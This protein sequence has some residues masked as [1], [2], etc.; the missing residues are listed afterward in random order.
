M[1][2]DRIS[3]RDAARK[4]AEARRMLET[5]RGLLAEARRSRYA[6]P[7]AFAGKWHDANAALE[8]HRPALEKMPGV[9]GH[10]IGYRVQD[11]RETD[12]QCVVVFVRSKKSRQELKHLRQ[13][14]VPRQLAHGRASI[15]IDVVDLG[16][17]RKQVGP[18]GS[19]GPVSGG[20]FGT[21]GA[22]VTDL[23]TGREAAITA[24]HVS[25]RQQIS[26]TNPPI[27]FAE[28]GSGGN[29][30]GNLVLGTTIG[31]DAA[32]VV[33]DPGQSVPRPL[34]VV[35][36]RPVSNDANAAVH[37]FGAV[38]RTQSGVIKY[39]NVNL[40]ERNL[41][42]T[43]LVSI[44]TERGDSGAGLV[45]NDKFLL[46]FLFGLAPSRIRGNLRVFCPADLVM[47]TLRCTL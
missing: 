8:K 15:G 33:L 26:A 31:I 13:R 36:F 27:P 32:K 42:N 5:A 9:V 17:V 23:D 16:R 6:P 44:T 25:G 21:I 34:P 46:G 38:S 7:Y 45:D 4:I 12:E 24:M 35:G 43:L 40:P 29:R 22:V 3:A 41:V 11:G 14:P 28:R 39:L 10:G 19:I 1:A 18:L 47:S 20:S 37:L 2:T 30:V